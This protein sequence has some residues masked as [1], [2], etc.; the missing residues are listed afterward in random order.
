MKQAPSRYI[1]QIHT[2]IVGMQYNDDEIQLSESLFVERDLNNPYDENAI[3]L[4][5]SSFESI[6][7]LPRKVSAWIAPLLD[8][9]KITLQ[10]STTMHTPARRIAQS[11]GWPLKLQ[12]F[13]EKRGETILEPNPAPDSE[14]AIVHEMV[15]NVFQNFLDF[16]DPNLILGVGRRL[17]RLA[18]RDLFPETQL[19]LALIPCKAE[20]VETAFQQN[21]VAQIQD[22]LYRIDMGYGLHHENLTIFPLFYP[23]GQEPGYTLLNTALE[24]GTA[25]IEEVNES[26][27][28]NSVMI[29][30]QGPLPL[31]V[32]EGA[33]IT[34]AKQNRVINVSILVSPGIRIRVPVCCVEQGRWSYT[35]RTFQT[36]HFAHPNLRGKKVDKLYA[37][38]ISTG[39][40]NSDQGEI[41][42]EVANYMCCMNL[43]SSTQSLTDGFQQVQ[44]RITAYREAFQL[45]SKTCGVMV[46]CGETA[47]GMDLFDHSDSFQAMWGA[48]GDAYFS[49]AIQEKREEAKTP[50]AI[51]K[52]I[53]C[54]IRDGIVLSKKN[55][56]AGK[57]FM[58]KTPA[59][60]GTGVW[61]EDK[62]RHMSVFTAP[63]NHVSPE[64]E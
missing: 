36:T 61:F 10:G 18:E 59:L 55:I 57:E 56:G 53:L 34:G 62:I 31:L 42:E 22:A 7:F 20:E 32:P 46:F 47:L 51:P 45:P 27:S 52:D 4:L 8:Q 14:K 60:V 28:V 43:H 9:G 19:L 23:N 2:K 30:N 29:H 58:V 41:W 37:D 11:G 54:Q 38:R 33:I 63:K 50:Q 17:T 39:E 25:V 48:I 26:G 24:E 6:G 13:L 15:R 1:G 21:G 12:V 5:N 40:A 3:R 35:S 44:D 64:M 16:P 49:Q